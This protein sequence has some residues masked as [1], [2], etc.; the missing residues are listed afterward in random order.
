[1]TL[2]TLMLCW[3]SM[4]ALRCRLAR[5]RRGRDVKKISGCQE[6]FL[7]SSDC[8]RSAAE[9]A[10]PDSVE[11]LK[12]YLMSQNHCP[13]SKL[14]L[15]ECVRFSSCLFSTDPPDRRFILD[16]LRIRAGFKARRHS[17]IF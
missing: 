11:V 14:Y 13:R 6:P 8:S 15:D 9:G 3:S 2:C 7:Q 10:I 12:N 17:H 1:M 4:A 16:A 5:A